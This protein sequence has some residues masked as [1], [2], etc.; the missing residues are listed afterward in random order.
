MLAM[1]ALIAAGCGDDSGDSDDNDDAAP[2]TLPGADDDPADDEIPDE[3]LVVYSGRSEELVGPLLEQFT[4]DTGIAVE[5]RY[6]DTAQMASLIL[7]E[8][9]NSPADVYYGQDA[10]ALGALSNAGR[11]AELDQGI[12]DLV[13]EGLRSPDGTWVGTSGRAR[14]VV[15]NTEALTEADL[16]ASILDFTDPKWSGRMGWAPTNGSFQAF[17]TAL[18]L[19][20]GE[21]GARA[22]LEGIMANDPVTYDNNIAIVEAVAAGEVEVGFVNHYYLQRFLAE[23]PDFTAANYFFPSDDPG[24]LVNVAGAGIVDTSDDAELATNLIEYLLSY[25]AQ[26]YFS[27]ETFEIPLV[28]DVDPAEGVPSLADINVPD[29]DL[30]A[31]DDLEGTLALLTDVGAL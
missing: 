30:G 5:V 1:F 23:D 31:I 19:V 25:E 10:G 6:G 17:V 7:T 16:P 4:A 29:I 27:G 24:G 3:T 8:G 20:E 21:D 13:P 15:Y 28:A 14:V 22:W 11:L 26:M 9:D 18:R 2:T 12:L